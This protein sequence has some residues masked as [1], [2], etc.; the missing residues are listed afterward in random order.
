MKQSE[1]Y[2]SLGS[3]L[4]DRVGYLNKSIDYISGLSGVT[5]TATSGI[6]ETDPVGVLDQPPF[7]NL[8]LGITTVLQPAELLNSVKEIERKVGRVHRDRWRER[9]IDIDIIFYSVDNIAT[10]SLTVP[11]ERAHLRRFVLQPLSD[12]APLFEHPVL[13][14][15]VLQ[16]LEECPDGSGVRLFHELSPPVN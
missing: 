10:D 8:A 7:L 4:G 13:H 6:Y 16:L 3:N 14:K 5:I 12:I 1:S 15:T 9:E 11:H 2:L